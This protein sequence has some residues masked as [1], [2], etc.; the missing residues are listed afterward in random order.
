MESCGEHLN[1]FKFVSF[2]STAWIATAT[3]ETMP[4]KSRLFFNCGVCCPRKKTCRL[5]LTTVVLWSV[6]VI[7]LFTF[8]LR[9]SKELL[10]KDPNYDVAR[11]QSEILEKVPPTGMNITCKHTLLH[12]IEE[13]CFIYLHSFI[14]CCFV[15]ICT[16]AKRNNVVLMTWFFMSLCMIYSIFNE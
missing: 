1:K 3:I 9:P 15:Y 12:Q 4:A 2:T 5:V 6:V 10:T 16:R 11:A 7:V 8:I 14:R 13:I